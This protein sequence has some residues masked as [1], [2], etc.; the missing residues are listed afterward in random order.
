[1]NGVWRSF[2]GTL[3]GN[4]ESGNCKDYDPRM[5]PWYIAATTGGKNLIV[6]IDTSGSM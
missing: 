1:M 6:I 3:Y 4:D 2:P 5:R